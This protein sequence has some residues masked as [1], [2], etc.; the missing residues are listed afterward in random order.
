MEALLEQPKAA[1]AVA[2]HY[3]C[4]FCEEFAGHQAVVLADD[5]NGG[6]RAIVVT[7]CV[8]CA[9]EIPDVTEQTTQIKEI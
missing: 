7:A 9:R 5:R 6:V 2:H 3:T 4:F 1:Q 8:S